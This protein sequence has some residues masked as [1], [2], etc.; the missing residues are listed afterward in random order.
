M[1]M[2]D[3]STWVSIV[4]STS[5]RKGADLRQFEENSAVVSLAADVWNDRKAEL[6]SA[7]QTAAEEI[8]DSEVTVR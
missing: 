8:A 7:S 4:R 5:D 1:P 3:Y 6:Q 2:V